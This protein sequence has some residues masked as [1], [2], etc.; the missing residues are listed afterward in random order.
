MK[1]NVVFRGGRKKDFW[2]LHRLL[3]EY[4]LSDMF[5]L[6]AKRHQWEHNEK[7]LLQKFTDFTEAENQPAPICLL[8]KDWD[9]IKL[10]LIDEAEKYSRNHQN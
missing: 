2:D 6:H 8:H 7:E 10:D 9:E 5:N 3:Q 4:P 1:M